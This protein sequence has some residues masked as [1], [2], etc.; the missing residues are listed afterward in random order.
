MTLLK[1]SQTREEDWY[2]WGFE[3]CPNPHIYTSPLLEGSFSMPAFMKML[4]R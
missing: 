3:L 2:M 1:K 4:E